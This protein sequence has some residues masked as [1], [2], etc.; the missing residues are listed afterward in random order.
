M[1]V[2]D[3][4]PRKIVVR[5]EKPKQPK[6]VVAPAAE[7]PEAKPAVEDMTGQRSWRLGY[8][9][10]EAFHRGGRSADAN[11]MWEKTLEL[12]PSERHEQIKKDRTALLAS[13]PGS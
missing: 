2:E 10:F 9:L 6:L 1:I 7:G 4:K 13:T 3:E 8:F 5:S 12:A 11:R